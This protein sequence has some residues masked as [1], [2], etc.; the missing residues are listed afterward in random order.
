MAETYRFG[1][2][3]LVPLGTIARRTV[4]SFTSQ[5]EA[6]RLTPDTDEAYLLRR[7]SDGYTG[8]FETLQEAVAHVE[9]LEAEDG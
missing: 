7:V 2:R 4:Y 9:L 6:Y 3:D 1:G 5:G 8:R